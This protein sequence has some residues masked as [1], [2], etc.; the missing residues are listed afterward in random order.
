M[1]HIESDLNILR[2]EVVL[3]PSGNMD[4]VKSAIVKFSLDQ[5]CWIKAELPNGDD[6]ECDSGRLLTEGVPEL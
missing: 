2:C 3:G 4:N 5:H 6:W 1:A